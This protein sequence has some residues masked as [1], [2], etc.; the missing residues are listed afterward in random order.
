MS[1]RLVEIRVT[2]DDA[3]AREGLASLY[4]QVQSLGQAGKIASQE[5]NKSLN[6][7]LKETAQ[8]AAKNLSNDFSKA[9][10]E[11]FTKAGEQSAK[12][13]GQSLRSNLTPQLAQLKTDIAG[14]TQGNINASSSKAAGAGLA[15]AFA[16]ISGAA[17]AT[18]AVVAGVA[19]SI[20]IALNAIDRG[21]EVSNL[22]NAFE[23]MQN[24]VG[25]S[26]NAINQFR[27][28]THGLISD[29]NL[30][31]SANLAVTLGVDDGSESFLKLTEGAVKLG[32]ALN[33]D[34]KQ[35]VDSLIIGI[36]RKSR[37]VLD[38]LG[39]I[40][41]AEEAYKSYAA[42]IHKSADAL[43][44]QEETLAFNK[45][46]MDAVIKSSAGL[47]P[48]L[49]NAGEAQ[50]QL[51]NA[52]QG[53]IDRFS[54]QINENKGLSSAL[55]A[56]GKIISGLDLEG[57]ADAV[58]FVTEKF[59]LLVNKLLSYVIPAI[60]K[61]NKAIVAAEY[62][63]GFFVRTAKNMGEGAGLLEAMR[64]AAKETS[65]VA[66][67]AEEA[68]KQFNGLR[69]SIKNATKIKDLE[70]ISGTLAA[71]KQAI[72]D[73]KI[74][75]GTPGANS[76]KVLKETLESELSKIQGELLIKTG[77]L[78]R[79]L[80]SAGDTM[81]KLAREAATAKEQL[82]DLLTTLTTGQASKFSADL[83]A[84]A[85]S[86]FFAGEGTEALAAGILKIK[87]AY[88]VTDNDI[89]EFVASAKQSAKVFDTL[90]EQYNKLDNELSK[91]LG[92]DVYEE[93]LQNA[94]SK[95]NDLFRKWK[96]GQ[97]TSI[98]Y[99]NGI[100][101]LGKE[102]KLQGKNLEIYTDYQKQLQEQ[103]EKT[104]EAAAQFSKETKENLQKT[105]AGGALGAVDSTF[106]TNILDKLVQSISGSANSKKY[107]EFAQS[108]AVGISQAIKT[109]ID[110]GDI[111]AAIKEGSAALGD[112][113]GGG[114]GLGQGIQDIFE[115]GQNS[116][117]TSQGI[118][119]LAGAA[120][121]AYFSGGNAQATAA[122]ADA[123]ALIG[124]GFATAFGLAAKD[125]LRDER[126]NF[127]GFF[128]E[129]SDA[130]EAEGK[131]KYL[132][133]DGR[134]NAEDSAFAPIV[135]D[136]ERIK[137]LINDPDLKGFN[138]ADF[139]ST[140]EAGN[141]II[142]SI[143]G[144]ILQGAAAGEIDL[145]LLPQFQGLA[146]AFANFIPDVNEELGGLAEQFG[147]ILA[148]NFKNVEG[149]NEFQ[150]L[151]QRSKVDAESMGKALEDAYFV[152]DLKAKDFLLSSSAVTELLKQ[153]IPFGDG[154]TITAFNNLITGGLSSGQQALDAFG[155][156]AVEAIEKFGS[157]ASFGD[158]K[159][160]LL[161][162][163]D[164]KDVE[165]FFAVLQNQGIDTFEELK[166]ITLGDT[167]NLVSQLQDLGFGFKEIAVEVDDAITKIEEFKANA[168]Q[169]IVTKYRIN[170]EV[171]GDDLPPGFE[172]A[173]G[174][175]P[176]ARF[177]SG[178]ALQ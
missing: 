128:N 21:Q 177:N 71:Q 159:Q 34:A 4:K 20:V 122:G 121:A 149:L 129:L 63:M 66:H 29:F 70:K 91:S 101:E 72:S 77:L 105:F 35:A 116:R 84:Q 131:F 49:I 103:L 55:Q 45:V 154:Q 19:G 15:V 174:E 93:S 98:N 44:E 158:L 104:T 61:F 26:E 30:M 115:I 2:L 50:Q 27:E 41:K 12:N 1:N 172:D 109:A 79:G 145:S 113:L 73:I 175:D 28:A 86:T 9:A 176:R 89:K 39:I 163:F 64:N 148:L 97:I 67:G 38:N 59:I 68:A 134:I 57:F 153:G 25:R 40:V 119:A 90:T 96:E 106:G 151:L 99:K 165:A 137:E 120:I 111:K 22:S 138:L 78:E 114:T 3:S 5:L 162:T 87:D 60:T 132:G 82:S 102:Y 62:G 31:Q 37:L 53:V 142:N 81:S 56:T 136:L 107:A 48:I 92:F 14:A 74:E 143:S 125:Q 10:K 170:V 7:G 13:F 156:I 171:T 160:Q 164:P 17:L 173:G 94:I 65:Y 42:T 85:R 135:V 95:S 140:D 52:T 80:A 112:A 150:L 100:I 117:Q 69:E 75:S 141:T 33:L 146:D 11:G 157:G 147:L 167:A 54:K 133:S 18:G 127:L 88:N 126:D 8:N 47:P 110:S 58:A 118:G 108:L 6:A 43:T 76:K 166:N 51:Q 161:E 16:G 144:A 169:E 168:E 32:R 155:D 123:G 139:I 46:A 130:I 36:G 152:G 178:P 83:D 24:S 23:L 124:D